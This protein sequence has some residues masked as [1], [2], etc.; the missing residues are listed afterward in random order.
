[1]TQ[2]VTSYNCKKV[3]Q[4]ANCPTAVCCLTVYGT[5][6]V[7]WHHHALAHIYILISTY[8]TV[9]YYILYLVIVDPRVEVI[10]EEIKQGGSEIIVSSQEC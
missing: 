9:H 8:I 2:F 4:F 3:Q 7:L 1:M 10:V 6:G 5:C